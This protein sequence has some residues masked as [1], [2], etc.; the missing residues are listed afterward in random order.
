MSV[1]K[2]QQ[3]APVAEQ[4][5]TQFCGGQ[6]AIKQGFTRFL[7][8]RMIGIEVVNMAVA[9][10]TLTSVHVR[11]PHLHATRLFRL[12]VCFDTLDSVW[13]TVDRHAVDLLELYCL[14]RLVSVQTAAGIGHCKQQQRKTRPS[15]DLKK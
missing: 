11:R 10:A 12:R 4:L 5:H 3:P 2:Q 7:D 14:R 6:G 8:G 13:N 15:S 9:L 1:T